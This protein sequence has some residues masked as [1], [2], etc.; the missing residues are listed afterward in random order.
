MDENTWRFAQ[1]VMWLIGLQTVILGGIFA[2]LWNNLSKRMDDLGLKLD[3]SVFDIN[4]KIDRNE[5]KFNAKLDSKLDPIEKDLVQI[6]T[7]IAVMESR[8]ADISTN[9][10]YLMWHQQALP[11]KD[12]EEQ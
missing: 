4:G 3:K 5:A 10:T 12:V 1:I 11:Q 6:N 7:K 2:F 9:V 8:L